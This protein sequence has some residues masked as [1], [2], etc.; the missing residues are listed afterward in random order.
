MFPGDPFGGVND[1]HVM[2]G[3]LDLGPRPDRAD[4]KALLDDAVYG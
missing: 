4:T 1:L 3:L 2:F